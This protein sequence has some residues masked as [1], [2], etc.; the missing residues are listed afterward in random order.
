MTEEEKLKKLKDAKDD[1]DK[2]DS[3]L[4]NFKNQAANNI[5]TKVTHNLDYQEEIAKSRIKHGISIGNT[6]FC[7][8]SVPQRRE[9][10]AMLKDALDCY[11]FNLEAQK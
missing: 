10:L 1:K 9:V 8:L 7:D 2:I 4:K 3:I 5:V 11:I 6:S